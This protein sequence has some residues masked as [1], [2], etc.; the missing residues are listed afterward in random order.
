MNLLLPFTEDI[1]FHRRQVK[2][3]PMITEEGEEQYEV[4]HVVAWEQRG[5]QL[6]YQ[7]RWKG[8]D[9]TEDTLERAEKIAELPQIMRDLLSR[10]PKAPTPK[11]FKMQ[12]RSIKVRGVKPQTSASATKP[13]Y[14][15]HSQL[16]LK[17]P[18]LINSYPPTCLPNAP[19]TRLSPSPPLP[20]A[21]LRPTTPTLPDAPTASTSWKPE[22]ISGT[23]VLPT[24]MTHVTGD[25]QI[26][27]KPSVPTP[28]KQAIERCD[29]FARSRDYAKHLDPKAELD[30]I[31]MGERDGCSWVGKDTLWCPKRG[32]LKWV[33]MWWNK[34]E[35]DDHDATH[36][37]IC[38]RWLCS[39]LG[40]TGSKGGR[41]EEE[42]G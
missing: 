20:A 9:P 39:R 14:H 25:S 29:S 38:S 31:P 33:G 18:P 10:Y 5:K 26:L 19:P 3:P 1:N 7:I 37:I 36:K 2:P 4:D 40:G 21:L 32:G 17:L 28:T 15:H 27:I 8:Y 6:Y 23:K 22:T 16:A 24:K 30:Y 41:G 13:R 42:E 11:N 12:I 35:S 34:P